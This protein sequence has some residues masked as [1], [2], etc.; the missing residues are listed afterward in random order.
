MII[1]ILE[2]HA[3]KFMW[4]ANRCWII[5]THNGSAIAF[6]YSSKPDFEGSRAII[7]CRLGELAEGFLS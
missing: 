7:N 3:W 6:R 5:D 4:V 2:I 1:K